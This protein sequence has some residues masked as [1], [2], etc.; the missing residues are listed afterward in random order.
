MAALS[1]PS[2]DPHLSLAACSRE[3]VATYVAP[4][5]RSE[6]P[7]FADALANAAQYPELDG[8][9]LGRL[10]TASL[11]EA[12]P[13]GM[14]V[15]DGDR[16]TL[17][18]FAKQMRMMLRANLLALAQASDR[19]ASNAQWVLFPSSAPGL[20]VRAEDPTAALAAIAA[21]AAGSSSTPPSP[22][23][24]VRELVLGVDLPSG[25]TPAPEGWLRVVCI[26]DTHGRHEKMMHEI[27]DGDVLI[28]AGDFTNTGRMKNSARFC[29]WF[30]SMPHP[31]KILIAGNHDT[32]MHQVYYEETGWQKFHRY[33]RAPDV[34]IRR[35]VR[36]HPGFTY[37]EDSGCAIG[38][39]TF[40]GSPWQPEFCDWAFNLPRGEACDE[41]WRQ[42]P[43]G[44][45]VLIT[46]GPALGHGDLCNGGQR[47]GCVN[48][49]AQ[50]TDRIKPRYHVAGHVHEGFGATTNGATTF[51][52]ASTCDF[53]YAPKHVA[54]VFDLPPREMVSL[55]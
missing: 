55:Q 13:L 50:I 53:A 26:S 37:L 20:K 35:L 32:T 25:A 27:P 3:D 51:V 15:A 10:I 39:Y 24:Q 19:T 12:S 54:V 44:T 40:W 43:S 7:A 17:S 48:L 5:L 18:M 23:L 22:L 47:A 29:T 49:L 14:L 38:G 16:A 4:R 1:S 6:L 9:A 31:R 45:D 2:Q 46:H 36:N 34:E 28:H 41:K 33:E 11:V 21:H 8:C 30:A 42:I 52:N